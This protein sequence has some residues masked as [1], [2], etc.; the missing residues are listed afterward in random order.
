MPRKRKGNVPSSC[1]SPAYVNALDTMTLTRKQQENV[2]VHEN[3]LG[4]RIR[5]IMRANN[6]KIDELRVEVGVKE[7]LRRNR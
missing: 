5:G 1:V 2:Q 4:R 6:R 7:S 3:N